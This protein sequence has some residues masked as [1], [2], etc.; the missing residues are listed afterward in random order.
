MSH[1]LSSTGE[2][3]RWLVQFV[4]VLGRFRLPLREV[5]CAHGTLRIV[6]RAEV[7]FVV[8]VRP[9][10]EG[11]QGWAV[12]E[13]FVLGYDGP[14]QLPGEKQRWME[15]ILTV[16]RRLEHILPQRLDQIGAVF[17]KE[18]SG[19]ERFAR[20]FSFC[21]VER[22]NVAG[23]DI[24]EVLVRAT[25]RCNQGCLFCSAPEHRSPSAQEVHQ[26]ILQAARVFPGCLLS[27]TGGEPTLRPTFK[28]EVIQAL[29]QEGVG[30]VQVQTNAV[31]FARTLD[32]ADLRPGPRLS[33]FASLHALEEELYDRCTVT[34]G[35]LPL[36]CAGIQR[37]I[38]AGHRV[39]IN[40]MIH[41][42]N[43][44]H[45]ESYLRALPRV[46]QLNHRVA[47]HFSTLICP[48]HRPKAADFLVPYSTLAPRVEA[49]AELGQALGLN[50]D[51]LRSSTHAAMPACVLSKPYRFFEARR[52][53]VRP[54]E[55]GYGDLTL[56]WVKGSSC[57]ECL[58]DRWCLGVPAAYA[59][60]FGLGEL[61]PLVKG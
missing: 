19:P 46:F 58:E 5:S 53:H 61:R 29:A 32:P 4:Q 20:L 50:M 15:G 49:A 37:L 31:A 23:E 27:L 25:T 7:P 38:D 9:R 17:G 56:P 41:S 16:L 59:R 54:G 21:D 51:P 42:I 48:E 14:G 33:F 40:C 47:V 28:D 22:N 6:L 36:A 12:T 45:L 18:V 60:R 3:P 2:N 24:V 10:V 57:S 34:S 8:T 39:T 35:Q 55:T 30:Q 13:R 26:C 1:P 52:P 43:L 44:E 11:A